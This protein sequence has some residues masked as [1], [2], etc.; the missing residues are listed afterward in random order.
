MLSY[1][2]DALRD[3]AADVLRRAQSAGVVRPDVEPA[4]VLRLIG[5]FVMGPQQIV[6]RPSGR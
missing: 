3:S 6:P 5:G 1:C 4:D 2:R